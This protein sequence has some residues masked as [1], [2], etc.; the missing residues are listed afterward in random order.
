MAPTSPPTCANPA[1]GLSLNY[2]YAIGSADFGG[3]P[4]SGSTYRWFLNGLPSPAEPVAEHLL[5]HLDASL[6]GS[7][8]EMPDIA[9]GVSYAPGRWGPALALAPGGALRYERP[10]NLDLSQG[11]VEM[12]V[13]PRAD[14]DDPVYGSRWHVLWLYLAPGGDWLAIA[15]SADTGVLYAGG[16]VDGQWQSAYGARAGTRAWRAGDWHHLAFTYSAAGNT[17]RFYLDGSLVADTNEG[18]TWPPSPDGADFSLGGDPWGNA[19]YYLVDEVRISGRMAPGDEIAARARRPDQP[20]GHEVWLATGSLA[21][22]DELAYEFTPATGTETGDPCLSS[23]RVYPGIPVTDPQP[24]STL[25]PPGTTAIS[26]T[27]QS[28]TS[29]TC[30]F[31]LGQ[32]LPFEEMAPFDQGAGT[33]THLTSVGGLDP[34]PN[35]VNELYVRCACHPDFALHLRY[36]SLSQ[37][38]PSFPRTGNLWGWWGFAGRPLADAARIDLWLGAG[39]DAGT[40]REL[41]N[42]NPAIRVLTSINAVE[43]PGLPDDY[44]LKDIYGNKVEVWPGSYRLNLTKLYVAE[45]QAHLA[46][47]LV[48]DNDL[49]FDGVFFDNVFTTQSWLDRDI[50]GQ[51]FLVDS[52]EDGVQDDPEAFDA[53]WKAGVYHEMET[54]RALMPEAIVSGH[55][56]DI[57][58]PGIAAAFNGISIGFWTAD[59][60]EGKRSFPQLWDH[61]HAW[62]ELARQPA[63]TMIESSPPDQIAYGYDYAPWSKI[64]PSTL[65][66]AR[67][68]YPYVR[69]GLALT[70]MDDGY[71]AHEFGDT[72]HGN[73]WWYDELDFDLAY[74]LGPAERVDLEVMPGENQ[75][76]NG[77]FEDSLAYPWSFWANTEEGCLADVSRDTT[78]AAEGTASA[79]IEV[80]ATSGVDWHVELAQYDRSLVEGTRYDVAFWAKSDAARTMTLS[81]QKGSPDWRNYGL[82]RQVLVGTAWQAYTVSFEASETA[83]DSRIQF[84]VGEAAGTV[85]LDD[86]RLRVRPPD[87]YRRLFGNGLVLLNGSRQAWDIPV[88]PGYR[89]LRGDQAPLY[90]TILDDGGDAFWTT[91]AWT[92]VAYDS[93]EWQASGPFYHDWGQGC[94]ERGGTD[95]EARW[96]LGITAADTYTITAWWPAAPEAAGWSANAIYEVI[97]GG[98]V[99]AATTLDQRSG[100]DEWHLVAEVPLAPGDGAQVRLR[101]PGS[102]PCIADA[103][104]L[105]S[106][107]RYN[108][109]FPARAVT[110]Q[111]LD[112][113]VLARYTPHPVDLPMV[114]RR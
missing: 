106:G 111:P 67:T 72:W 23:P 21:A 61:Y 70:L 34:T 109:G 38:N 63:A 110:L 91:G 92:E 54:F 3:E 55:A 42:L 90:E 69:F 99:V 79:R 14:G 52:N 17:M 58:E 16:V 1:V 6:Q 85:W 53:A 97:A 66:F 22:G 100:G 35:V 26:L 33:T 64:P 68:Y 113:I 31:A 15:Q 84:M 47:Q 59:V 102:A 12:W 82:W 112:G 65:E 93:G 57:Y 40:I 20:R 83:S 2:T 25:L 98:Q 95:G 8:G 28:I 18:Q 37:A 80:T 11:T 36:R 48:L 46:Y 86:V 88:G 30:A 7:G 81:A 107:A 5:L 41:R 77:G 60:I 103:L 76:V 44:Y 89:R 71:F 51:P 108:D 78:S 73:D 27:V 104:H 43:H 49:M 9:Q 13:A 19:A 50:Y 96:A 32:A 101:C 45:H 62:Q 75:I 105:R 94:H 87:V 4:E 114:W 29:T 24:P 10:G 74:P 56:M 39:F